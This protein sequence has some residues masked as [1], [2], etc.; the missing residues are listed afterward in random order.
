LCCI[1]QYLSTRLPRA[2]AHRVGTDNDPASVH[3]VSTSSN[4][5][6]PIRRTSGTI[7]KPSLMM[8]LHTCMLL[9]I[10]CAYKSSVEE[11]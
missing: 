1:P 7:I 4:N 8:G 6:K 11:F 2:I 9:W 10:T 3:R 5:N